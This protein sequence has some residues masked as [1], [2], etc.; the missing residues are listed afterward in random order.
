MEQESNAVVYI[1]HPK[2]REI[3]WNG[4]ALPT[5]KDIILSISDALRLHHLGYFTVK[6]KEIQKPPYNPKQWQNKIYGFTADADT[7]SG[8]G[9]CTTNLLRQSLK[10]GYDVRW[11]GHSVDVPDLSSLTR[12]E[13]PNDIGMVWHEQPNSRWDTSS[14]ERN[15]AITPFE[16]TRV[17]ISWVSRLNSFDAV[18]VPCKQNIQM[19]KDSGVTVPIELIHWGIDPKVTKPQPRDNDGLFTFGTYGALS[20]RKGTDLLIR[21]FQKAFSPYEYKDVRLICKTSKPHFYF[22]PNPSDNRIIIDLMRTDQ[23]QIDQFYR[24]I[25]V[26]VFPFTGEGFGMCPLETAGAGRPII[27]TG[28]SGPMDY[29]KDEIGW[30]LNY[31]LVPATDFNTKVYKED[32]GSWARADENQL[33]QLMRYAYEHRDEVKAKGEAAKEY[34]QKEWTWDAQA[35]TYF[36]ALK[37]HL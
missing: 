23:E 13:I 27:I 34:V 24:K 20:E 21:A 36:A 11:I 25:D 4:L 32:C 19:M 5:N 2:A 14:F 16:T 12:K 37:K 33:I 8:F 9:N 30:K 22:K 3:Y 17:P 10:A 35:P 28:W 29:F 6:I 1:E 31:T 15:I 26:G 7:Q 18:F